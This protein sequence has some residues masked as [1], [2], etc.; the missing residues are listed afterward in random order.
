M[1]LSR[2]SSFKSR[3]RITTAGN[4]SYLFHMCTFQ[5]VLLHQFSM[6]VTM[7]VFSSFPDSPSSFP[8]RDEYPVPWSDKESQTHSG[9]SI[10]E[11]SLIKIYVIILHKPWLSGYY[12]TAIGFH[13]MT[14]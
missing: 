5:N 14:S 6:E 13:Q 3:A 8:E 9:F 2:T 10:I 4:Y 7:C 11:F 1:Q 12:K